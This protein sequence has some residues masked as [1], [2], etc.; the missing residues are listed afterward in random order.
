VYLRKSVFGAIPVA[1][2]CP[3]GCDIE[4]PWTSLQRVCATGIAPNAQWQL[5]CSIFAELQL[6]LVYSTAPR[7]DRKRVSM[8]SEAFL[9]KIS[10]I[11]NDK[12]SLV[13]LLNEID[14]NKRQVSTRLTAVSSGRKEVTEMTTQERRSQIK[15]MQDKMIY[16]SEE[17]EYVRSR[18]AEINSDLKTLNRVVNRRSENFCHAFVAAAERVLDEELFLELESRAASILSIRK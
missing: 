2:R 4:H 14:E 3:L 16:L 6:S 10:E 7:T 8:I 12:Q 17:R 9:N 13:A 5:S 1:E 18:I 11:G 15:L